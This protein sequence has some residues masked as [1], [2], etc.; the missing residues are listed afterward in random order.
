MTYCVDN[1]IFTKF[2]SA[3]YD[4]SCFVCW[5]GTNIWNKCSANN[6]RLYSET[7][8]ST[9]FNSKLDHLAAVIRCHFKGGL[10]IKVNCA[11]ALFHATAAAGGLGVPSLLYQV[12]QRYI[13]NCRQSYSYPL[14]NVLSS[15][16]VIPVTN[17]CNQLMAESSNIILNVL[18]H[19]P[20]WDHLTCGL[21]VAI[22]F[23]VYVLSIAECLA[24]W[25]NQYSIYFVCDAN[26]VMLC[27]KCPRPT[28]KVIQ[29]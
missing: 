26:P 3:L 29:V 21:H 7:M 24:E 10:E 18:R 4:S 9:V 28:F 13:R 1:F 20:G 11:I 17:W 19:V 25:R 8:F 22:I 16:L 27:H 15:G 5:Q 14:T 2:V 12:P 6:L 23:T